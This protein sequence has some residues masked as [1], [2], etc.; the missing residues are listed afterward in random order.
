MKQGRDFFSD[1]NDKRKYVLEC[2]TEFENELDRAVKSIY[3]SEK[4]RIITLSGPSCSGKTTTAKKIVRDFT[5]LGRSVHVISIDDFYRD[6]DELLREA[7]SENLTPDFDSAK[8]IDIPYLG[9]AI[10]SIFSSDAVTI[11]KFDFTRG[12]KTEEIEYRIKE[13]D[14][15][16]FE[17]IQAMYP[18]V[19]S[20]FNGRKHTSIYVSVEDTLC[21]CG[22]VF[23][24]EEIR[25]FRRLVRDYKFRNSSPEFTFEIWRSVRENEE[26]NIFPYKELCDIKI[27]S[28]LSYEISMIKP[29]LLSLLESISEKS[30]YYGKAQEII[31]K[32]ECIPQI[33]AEYMPT[34]SVYHEFLG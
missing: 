23:L 2:E 18:E 24:P 22:E 12:K 30:E 32:I 1:E 25:F 27:N 34:E 31:N 15:F 8:S 9:R 4:A 14:V 21:V 13:N 26:K 20:L 3:S 28:L 33:S 29:Y 16:I 7:E 10:D 19:T 5:S 17:G 11:P 6:R